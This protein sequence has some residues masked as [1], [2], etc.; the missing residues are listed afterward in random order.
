MLSFVSDRSLLRRFGCAAGGARRNPLGAHTVSVG[1]ARR[2]H[3]DAQPGVASRNSLR[4]LRSLRSN[5]RAESVYEAR[6]ARQPQACASRRH[7][8]RPQRIAPGTA[9]RD[10]PVVLLPKE[11]GVLGK[12]TY[13]QA[14][15][16]LRGA[17][18]RR[19][20]GRARSAL[21]KLTRRTCSNAANEVRVVS[22]ATGPETEHR[23]EVDAQRRPPRRSAAACPYVPLP[24]PSDAKK[25]GH[26]KTAQG[27][28]QSCAKRTKFTDF[29]ARRRTSKGTGVSC[30]AGGATRHGKLKCNKLPAA[31]E[32]SRARSSST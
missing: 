10:A 32:S 15:A 22:C 20:R 24:Q 4:E 23:R 2:L 3:C 11:T 27:R 19:A 17:E 26:R 12:G 6:C 25:T 7:P 9:C 5:K 16:R 18:K 21:R 28:N 29:F 1:A 30:V 8:N 14:A 31:V 13:G